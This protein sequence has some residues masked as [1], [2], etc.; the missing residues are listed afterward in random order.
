MCAPSG[1]LETFKKW[2]EDA[3][4]SVPVKVASRGSNVVQCNLFPLLKTQELGVS[5]FAQACTARRQV[6]RVV[7]LTRGHRLKGV[8][9]FSFQSVFVDG[10]TLPFV[11]YLV[12]L[13]IIKAGHTVHSSELG[14]AGSV[15]IKWPNDIYANQVKIGGILCQS[16]YHNGFFSVPTGAFWYIRD[17]Q[18]CLNRKLSLGGIGIH[19]FNREECL[20]AFCNVYEPMEKVFLEK[21]F[22]PFMA[23]YWVRWLHTDE[24]VQVANDDERHGENVLAIIKGLTSTGC[25]LPF[26]EG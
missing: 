23:S 7:A 13:A 16:E 25:R 4:P 19:I 11:H 21:G 9:P 17:L 26:S 15:R 2:M 22:E 6:V 3:K 20:A 1:T 12:A 10:T 8:L 5:C 24:P 18:L 14:N